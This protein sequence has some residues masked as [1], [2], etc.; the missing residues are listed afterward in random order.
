VAGSFAESL[1]S[2]GFRANV[3]AHLKPCSNIKFCVALWME[4][5]ARENCNYSICAECRVSLLCCA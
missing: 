1:G 4:L 2:T 3:Q 5:R